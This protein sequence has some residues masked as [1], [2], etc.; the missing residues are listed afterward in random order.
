[1]KVKVVLLVAVVLLAASAYGGYL[2]NYTL[3]NTWSPS[4]TLRNFHFVGVAVTKDFIVL[5]DRENRFVEEVVLD[6]LPP[7]TLIRDLS[8]YRR[9]VIYNIDPG[10]RASPLAPQRHHY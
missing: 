9:T 7:D 6:G 5:G 8:R 3:Y 2:T 10:M 1:M 4:Y